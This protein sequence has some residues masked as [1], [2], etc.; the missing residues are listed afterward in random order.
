MS[1]RRYANQTAEERLADQKQRLITAAYELFGVLGYTDT[2]VVDICARASVSYRTFYECFPDRQRG[3][4]ELLRLVY[5]GCAE[6]AI[7]T[8]EEAVSRLHA[9]SPDRT[10]LAV[11][12]YV[13]FVTGD[14]RRARV[15]Y[16][17]AAT[18]GEHLLPSRDR[19]AE[20]LAALLGGTDHPQGRLVAKGV[21]AASEGLLAN[22][23]HTD[24]STDDISAAA[25]HIAERAFDESEQAFNDAS[26]YLR[27]KPASQ[28][29]C[30]HID[31]SVAS[32]ARMY[33]YLLGGKDNY[34]VDRAAVQRLIELMPESPD[35]AKANRAFMRRAVAFAAAAVG[36][37]VD[38]GT[39]IPTSPNVD[40]VVRQ[41][42]PEVVVVGIDNDPIVLSHGRA[43]R[44][45]V[46]IMYGD[47]RKPQEVVRRL[48]KVID[49]G[50]PVALV[51]TSLFNFIPDD[52]VG[53][54][55]EFRAVMAPGSMLVISHGTDEGAPPEMVARFRE[56][57]ADAVSPAVFRG[58]AQIEG[59]FDG[60]TLVEPGLVDVQHWRPDGVAE[61]PLP[62]RMLGGI[63]HIPR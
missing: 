21:L 39:G 33:D 52:P 17:E 53:I 62:I 37:F 15:L 29:S 35:L 31:T 32:T 49:F 28:E 7:R 46:Q 12:A 51:A 56:V 43:L 11:D 42:N 14:P 9:Y 13:L 23:A 10:R 47:V 54:V 40:E 5:E 57:Y 19:T 60:F 4:L 45:G 38:L 1:G 27:W 25:M 41:M 24:T 22:W 58:V 44:S 20:R 48:A 55:G 8:V 63:G 34:A 6:E 36:Q 50:R 3:R 26:R 30:R 61:R 59:I 18:G 2:R 16:R